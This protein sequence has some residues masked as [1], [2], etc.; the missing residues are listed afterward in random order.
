MNLLGTPPEVTAVAQLAEGLLRN[1]PAIARRLFPELASLAHARRQL[2]QMVGAPPSAIPTHRD[3]ATTAWAAL[4]S[5]CLIAAIVSAAMMSPA[6]RQ[7]RWVPGETARSVGLPAAIISITAAVILLGW[8]HRSAYRREAALVTALSAVIVGGNLGF[9]VVAGSGDGRDF[10]DVDMR[11]WVIA[12]V[13]LLGLHAILIAWLIRRDDGASGSES[14]G[15]T[16]S[17]ALRRRAASLAR[18]D[19]TVERI[20]ARHD[21]EWQEGLE[22]LATVVGPKPRAQATRMGPRAWL[23]WA[24]AE[25]MYTPERRRGTSRR[26]S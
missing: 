19:L 6:G 22:R 14:H 25:G 9:R 18:D 16:P 12:S 23:V 2:E 15:P 8:R 7:S 24:V 13:I 21:T 26:P 10:S 11:S 17:H 4:L 5:L 3:W 20:P 1:R